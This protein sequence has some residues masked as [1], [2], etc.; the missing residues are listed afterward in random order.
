MQQPLF[1][2]RDLTFQKA[3]DLATRAESASKQQKSIRNKT[4][5]PE[6]NKATKAK[7][8]N[9]KGQPN[10]RCFRCESQHDPGDCRFRN[11]DCRYCRKRGHIETACIMK[12]KQSKKQEPKDTTSSVCKST[13]D[14]Q[15]GQLDQGSFYE[16]NQV[17]VPRVCPKF[18]VMITN[19][20]LEFEVDSGAACSLISEETFCRTC[21]TNPP[22]LSGDDAQLRTWSG[23]GL[24][25]LG[26]TTVNVKFKSKDC[27]LQLLVMK[28]T[29]CNLLGRDWFQVLQ[30]RVQGINQVQNK[31][32]CRRAARSAK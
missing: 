26:S 19:K 28:G 10:R 32:L 20:K 22:R 8:D 23:G 13:S 4:D 27:Q 31:Q 5:V 17:K 1:A 30:I 16:L 25:L 21:P 18:L 9:P 15:L 14:D 2:E 6:V 11:T 29:G 12:K 3:F 24:K 7:A